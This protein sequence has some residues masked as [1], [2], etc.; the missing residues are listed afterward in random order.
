MSGISLKNGRSL[1][2]LT[3]QRDQLPRIYA[4]ATAAITPRTPLQDLQVDLAP[5]GPPARA[6]PPGATIDVSQTTI[7]VAPDVLNDALDSD[8]RQYLSA[9]LSAVGEGVAGRGPDLRELF[10]AIGPTARQVSQ[11]TEALSGRR[12]EL[13]R[14]VHALSLIAA[15]GGAR[16][17]A[18]AQ[19]VSGGAQTL[20]AIAAEDA[21]LRASLRLLPS[22]LS[23][24]RDALQHGA[25]LS[26]QLQPTAVALT[27]ALAHLPAALRATEAVSNTG[28]RSLRTTLR[29][30][31]RATTPA[32][33]TLRP[34]LAHLVAVTPDLANGFKV[35]EYVVDE[36]FYTDGGTAHSYA[37]WLAWAQHDGNSTLST[38]DAQG[39]VVRSA[40]IF[41]CSMLDALPTLTGALSALSGL[42]PTICPAAAN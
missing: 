11:L 9:L 27:P 18:I 15:A 17:G 2:T 25:A 4:N 12:Q 41:S 22:T 26:A 29:P 3:V 13:A 42:L 28:E 30:F 16:A 35:L 20:R 7:P 6:L 8:T 1:V 19:A 23:A 5:G 14:V 21:P 36:L 39:Q 38:G 34:A 37:Y 10:E 24:A 33:S 32:L 31:V 40:L